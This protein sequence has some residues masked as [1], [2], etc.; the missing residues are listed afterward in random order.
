[1][2]KNKLTNYI[3]LDLEL[4]QPSNTII[5]I[6]YVIANI[7][8]DVILEK[9]CLD[10]NPNEILN[11]FIIDL[12]GIK[13]EDVDKGMTLLDA[14][15]VLKADHVKHNCF[16]NPVTWGGGDS[17]ELMKQ[18]K[19]AGYTGDNIFG[20]RWIDVKTVWHFKRINEQAPLQGGLARSM[21]KL[22]LKFEGRK[23]NA[24]DDS[25][26]TYKMFQALRKELK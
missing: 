5:Q 13:Q 26:N 17:V 22:G 14:F 1:M 25:L 19:V 10:V 8:D 24:A 18:L 12:T 4:N 7:Y 23:H 11:P 9:K 6:G 16:C 3:F 15:E 21:T 20:R 2:S